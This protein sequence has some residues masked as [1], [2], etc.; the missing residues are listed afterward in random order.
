MIFSETQLK[1]Y[2][3]VI[4]SL[5][6]KN[7]NSTISEIHKLTKSE[8]ILLPSEEEL[9]HE[10]DNP[11]STRDK[12]LVGK[13]IEYA[14]FGIKPNPDSKPDLENGYDIKSCAFKQLK[15]GCKNAKERQTLTNCTDYENLI[16]NEEF[17]NCKYYNKCKKLVLF[18]RSDDK[19][20]LKTYDELLNQRLLLVVIVNLDCLPNE[21]LSVINNDYELIRNCIINKKITQA[22]QKYLHIHKH[23][24]KNSETRALGYT[25]KLITQLAAITLSEILNVDYKDI[26]NVN[27]NGNSLS[28]HD[29]YI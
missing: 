25:P 18:I 2:V 6:F 14:F 15:N 11:K 4:N 16:E 21:I 22:G 27:V 8:H 7:K 17:K 28:I 13:F 12:G 24:S 29:K 9:K 1:S 23:G 5:V 19:I 3:N 10:F 20:K 26:I